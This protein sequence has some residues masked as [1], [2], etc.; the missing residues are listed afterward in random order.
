MVV[1]VTLKIK[2]SRVDTGQ[3]SIEPHA[4][5]YYAHSESI[6]GSFPS[7]DFRKGTIKNRTFRSRSRSE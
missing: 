3:I 7:I 4:K 2:K 1:D 5:V 6:E